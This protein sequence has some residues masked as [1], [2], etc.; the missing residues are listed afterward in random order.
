M[1]KEVIHD[2]ADDDDAIKAI[3]ALSPRPNP[4]SHA[5]LQDKVL[6]CRGKT[7]VGRAGKAR[8]QLIQIMHALAVTAHSGI[9]AAE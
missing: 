2:Y 4:I 6:T 8:K 3:K 1:N 7:W 9:L 5:T